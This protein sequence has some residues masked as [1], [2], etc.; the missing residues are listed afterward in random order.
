MKAMD[1]I[2]ESPVQTAFRA[3]SADGEANV[4]LLD[5]KMLK[6]FRALEHYAWERKPVRLALTFDDWHPAQTRNG[7][8]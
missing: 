1:A 5:G 2:R 6:A 3:T 8:L 4:I 7:P